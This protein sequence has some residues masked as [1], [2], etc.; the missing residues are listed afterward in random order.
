MRSL[1]SLVLLGTVLV[2]SCATVAAAG[3]GS[4]SGLSQFAFGPI[5]FSSFRSYSFS[6]FGTYPLYRFGSYSSF[7]VVIASADSAST[8]CG[9]VAASLALLGTLTALM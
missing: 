3:Y 6:S 4:F 7:S 9:K 5:T 8:L 1:G 2:V